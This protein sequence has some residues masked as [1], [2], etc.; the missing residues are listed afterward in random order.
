MNKATRKDFNKSDLYSIN[1]HHSSILEQCYVHFITR[2][3]LYGYG[4]PKPSTSYNFYRNEHTVMYF[5]SIDI[6]DIKRY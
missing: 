3:A 2:I 6:P 1:C 4:I 5:F